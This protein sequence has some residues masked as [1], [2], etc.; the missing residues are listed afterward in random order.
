MRL[1]YADIIRYPYR[2]WSERDELNERAEGDLIIDNKLLPFE[3]MN[4][5]VISVVV[6]IRC[7]ELTLWQPHCWRNPLHV[8]PITILVYNADHAILCQLKHSKTVI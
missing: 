6:K 4:K 7:T 8:K 2:N 1:Y 5:L 3:S